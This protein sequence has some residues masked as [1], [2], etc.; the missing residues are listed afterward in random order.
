M[1]TK[2]TVTVA[3]M[4]KRHWPNIRTYFTHRITNA[5]SE[6]MNAKIQAVKRRA[7]GFRSRVR[8]PGKLQYPGTP[9]NRTEIWDFE[10]W[11]QRSPRRNTRSRN[12]QS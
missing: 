9:P 5:G 8:F 4:L 10:M 3:A 6:S 1:K 11:K 7:C 2:M 12:F